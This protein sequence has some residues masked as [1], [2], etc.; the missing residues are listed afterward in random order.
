MTDELLKLMQSLSEKFDKG[1]EQIDKRFDSVE[2]RLDNIEQRLEM[3]TE[4]ESNT[5][6]DVIV[7][8]KK[9]DKQTN[10]ITKDIDYLS[11][12]VGKHDMILNRFKN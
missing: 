11:K 12:Q 6:E 7:L 1:F 2:K 9:I 4:K 10:D 5:N 8:L 3:M